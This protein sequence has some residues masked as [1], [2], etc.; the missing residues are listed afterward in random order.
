M[1]LKNEEISINKETSKS[2]D[3]L[4][5]SFGDDNELEFSRNPLG[6]IYKRNGDKDDL[7]IKI[8]SFRKLLNTLSITEDSV[9][10]TFH[11][12]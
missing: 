6:P 5:F 9:K 2:E 1:I 7:C 11:D 3:S 8:N 12:G 10:M 4:L